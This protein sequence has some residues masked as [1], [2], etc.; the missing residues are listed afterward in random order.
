GYADGAQVA[1]ERHPAHRLDAAGH[2]DPDLTGGDL[3]GE[4]V[5]RLLGRAAL[6]VDRGQ[7]VSSG[8]PACSQAKRATLPDCSPAWVTQPPITS[9]TRSAARPTRSS[10][11]TWV[12]ASSSTACNPDS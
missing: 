2:P 3:G 12:R 1:A 4:Q 6:H 11:A 10:I 8:R 9:L 5:H 7:A